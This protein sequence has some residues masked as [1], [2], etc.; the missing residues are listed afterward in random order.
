MSC[1]KSVPDKVL[2]ITVPNGLMHG[3]IVPIR[4]I[5]MSTPSHIGQEARSLAPSRKDTDLEASYEHM[6]GRV[7]LWHRSDDLS[8]VL[9]LGGSS[10]VNQGTGLE[11]KISGVLQ[12]CG[13]SSPGMACVRGSLASQMLFI[14]FSSA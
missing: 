5:S 8:F 10:A 7:L 4:G 6:H 12:V 14:S 3:H 13:D 11:C 9:I 2:S 1:L